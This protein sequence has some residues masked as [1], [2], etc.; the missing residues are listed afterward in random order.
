MSSSIISISADFSAAT[1][2]LAGVRG[3]IAANAAVNRVAATAVANLLRRHFINRNQQKSKHT[4]SNYW[5]Q[6]A[7]AVYTESNAT[8]GVV[9]VMHPGIR[10]HRYGGTIKPKSGKALAIPLRAAL[11]GVWPSE[12]FASRK[13][14]FVWRKGGK[15]FLAAR[16]GKGVTAG[17]RQLRLLYLLVKSVSKRPDPSVLP[18][19]KEM[20]DT[21][22]AA[23]QQFVARAIA[24]HNRGN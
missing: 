5:S 10:W 2:E 8:A 7:E 24:R 18:Q 12:H 1:A 6:V 16:Q 3:E 13:D 11:Y 19:P 14:A 21:A 17:G 9:T 15:A 20:A 4:Q 22:T 23:V